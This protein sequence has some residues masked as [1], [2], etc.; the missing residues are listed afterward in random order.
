MSVVWQLGALPYLRESV[1]ETPQDF[2]PIVILD[3]VPG[4]RICSSDL[5]VKVL[6]EVPLSC[7]C[8][9][10]I[11]GNRIRA[12]RMQAL[13]A[14][15]LAKLTTLTSL[16]VSDTEIGDA[17]LQALAQTHLP[18]TSLNVSN[19]VLGNAGLQALA[20]SAN[21]PGLTSLNVSYG[22]GNDGLQALADSPN[23]P[24]LTSLHVG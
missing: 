21:F 15:G 16:N 22:F 9:L 6:E 4:L 17:E 1:V 20:N 12:K 24:G 18:L 11:S 23:F 8:D 14:S 13:I 2:L 3:S 10:D 7:L 19:N 5:V